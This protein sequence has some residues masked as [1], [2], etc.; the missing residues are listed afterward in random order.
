[1]AREESDVGLAIQETMGS[2]PRVVEEVVSVGVDDMRVSSSS[3]VILRGTRRAANDFFI[4]TK[5]CSVEPLCWRIEIWI[6]D[7]V[8]RRRGRVERMR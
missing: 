3:W 1:M 5:R 8:E 7:T 2:L 4:F 6:D